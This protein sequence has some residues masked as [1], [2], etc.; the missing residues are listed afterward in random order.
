LQ[1]MY[2]QLEVAHNK[3]E[4]E[5]ICPMEEDPH[6]NQIITLKNEEGCTGKDLCNL[7]QLT[8]KLRTLRFCCC[9]LDDFLGYH[10]EEMNALKREY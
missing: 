9:S 4:E 8:V 7:T 6:E 1:E 5:D 10:N 2:E 3:E